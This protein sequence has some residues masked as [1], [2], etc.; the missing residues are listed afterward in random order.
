LSSRGAVALAV[1]GAVL[2]WPAASFAYRPFDSTDASVAAT[3]ELELEL[4]PVGYLDDGGRRSLVVPAL[5]ANLGLAE[6][7]ELVAQGRHLRLLGSSAGAPRSRL[8]DTGLFFKGVLRPGSLQD[9]GGPSIATELG[10]LLPTIGDAPGAGASATLIVSQRWRSLT[11]HVNAALAMSRAQNADLFGGLIVEG[12]QAWRV[13]PVTELFVEREV[14]GART[15]SWLT[16]FIG[17]VHED[18]SLDAA[19]RVAWVDGVV[20]REVRAGVT[21]AF[22]AWR[23]H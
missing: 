20:T 2:V 12:P 15:A 4:G 14:H 21:W 10:L 5:V 7:L 11:V 6:G 3:G 22:P 18:V 9:H 23:A 16:G 8:T 19:V 17:S 13:R 1:G